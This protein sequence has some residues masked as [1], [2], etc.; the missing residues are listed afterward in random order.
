[1][2]RNRPARVRENISHSRQI[3]RSATCPMSVIAIR[4]TSP[5]LEKLFSLCPTSERIKFFVLM[6]TKLLISHLTVILSRFKDAPS[7]MCLSNVCGVVSNTNMYSLH[8]SDDGN[9]LWKGLDEYF[10]FYNHQRLHQS[11][12]YRTPV[13]VYHAKEGSVA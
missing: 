5:S 1:M 2:K 7:T 4:V 13:E 11:L 6:M 9:H 3:A 12:N 10:R 8:V